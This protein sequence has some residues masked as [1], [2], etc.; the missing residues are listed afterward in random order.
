MSA[1]PE[2]PS[3]YGAP[4][5]PPLRRPWRPPP[6]GVGDLREKGWAPPGRFVAWWFLLFAADV[7]FYV[8][9]TPIWLGLRA[10]AW[11]AEL[12]SRAGRP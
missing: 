11:V 10:A 1:G 6:G 3:P 7:V 9:L 12:R 5:E 8:L 4:N 2:T